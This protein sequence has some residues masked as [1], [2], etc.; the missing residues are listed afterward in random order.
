[1]SIFDMGA[2]MHRIPKEMFGQQ[3]KVNSKPRPCANDFFGEGFPRSPKQ[4]RIDAIAA[5]Y[6]AGR[7]RYETPPKQICGRCGKEFDIVCVDE[8]RDPFVDN[9]CMH[10]KDRRDDAIDITA[11]DVC[12]GNVACKRFFDGSCNP[13]EDKERSNRTGTK[14]IALCSRERRKGE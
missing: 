10:C 1:M 9:I 7:R 11:T 5:A 13:S 12:D 4:D 6:D 8:E 14:E 2:N 3:I